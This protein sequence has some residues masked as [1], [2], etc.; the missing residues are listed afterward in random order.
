MITRERCGGVAGVGG[1]TGAA[2]AAP[3]AATVV[4]CGGGVT[5][6]GFA[7]TGAYLRIAADRHYA[8]DVLTGSAVGSA[9]GFSVPYL[10]HRPVRDEAAFIS[11][12]RISALPVPNGQLL[13]LSGLW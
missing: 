9:I 13:V 5:T 1:T 4:G 8:T 3:V 12:L 11:Q 7:T 6:G 10:A 2:C